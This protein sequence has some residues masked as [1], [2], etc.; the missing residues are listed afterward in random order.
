MCVCVCRLAQ[1]GKVMEKMRLVGRMVLLSPTEHLPQTNHQRSESAHVQLA[2][3]QTTRT[4]QVHVAVATDLTCPTSA[5][6][7]QRGCREDMGEGRVTRLTHC[8]L[9]MVENKL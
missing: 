3:H 9:T 2:H 5:A 6:R 8:L 7:L 4:T 1:K